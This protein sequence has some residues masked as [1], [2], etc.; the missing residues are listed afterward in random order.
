MI[1]HTAF[2][3]FFFFFDLINKIELFLFYSYK[4]ENM[5]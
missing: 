4:R 2:Y 5:V 1:H 3:S